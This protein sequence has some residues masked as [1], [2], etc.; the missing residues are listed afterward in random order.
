[1]TDE[2]DALRR[3]FL[4][5]LLAV[6]AAI[7]CLG[8]VIAAFGSNA[9][10][11]AGVAERWLTALSDATREGVEA[12]AEA[13][14]ASLEVDGRR[15]GSDFLGSF[16][17]DAPELTSGEPLFATIAVGRAIATDQDGVPAVD[18]PAQGTLDDGRVASYY[19][20]LVP[21]AGE[22][23]VDRLVSLDPDSCGDR[24]CPGF[25]LDRPAHAP[26]GFFVGAVALGLLVAA[27]C[28]AAIRAATPKDAAT[29]GRG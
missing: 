18:V 11:P 5:G 20:G 17:P 15:L 16:P 12:D 8:G 1:M 6:V 2:L 10:R 13:R 3:P 24:P 25:P 4:L 22:W 9:D 23:K 14:M 27:G 28:S 21:A 26:L 29:A 19:V 7:V